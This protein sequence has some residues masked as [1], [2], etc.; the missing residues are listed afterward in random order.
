MQSTYASFSLSGSN[1]EASYKAGEESK[2]RGG[3]L[4]A[5]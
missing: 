2:D 5:A 1:G 3:I 4:L